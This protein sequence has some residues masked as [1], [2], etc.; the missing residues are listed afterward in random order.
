MARGW[1]SKSVESQVEA[2]ESQRAASQAAKIDPVEAERRRQ[3]DSLLLSRTRILHDIQR[4]QNP[5]YRET[6][7]AALKHID[8]KLSELG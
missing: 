5:R 1:E 2:R 3:R 7:T 4:A 8:G 6:L